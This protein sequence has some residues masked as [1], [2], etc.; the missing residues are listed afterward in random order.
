MKAKQIYL[1]RRMKTPIDT[2]GKVFVHGYRRSNGTQ[3]KSYWRKLPGRQVGARRHNTR[4]NGQ[5]PLFQDQL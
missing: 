2:S 4:K 3:V 5:I 1:F